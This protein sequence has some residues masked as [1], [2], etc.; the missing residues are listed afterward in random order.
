MKIK[1][2]FTALLVL[3]FSFQ[4]LGQIKLSLEECRVMALENN[5]QVQIADEHVGAAEALRKSAKTNFLPNI[6]ANGS[7]T[8]TNKKFSLLEEDLFIPVV[9]YS[10]LDASGS[11]LN[12]SL[13]SPTLAD[14]TTANPQFDASVFSQTFAVDPSTGT[15]YVDADN[16]PVFGNYA[17]IPQE[18]GELGHKNIYV[19]ALTLTQP[20]YLGGK[21]R[22]AYKITKY[23][24][25][26]AAASKEADVA[27]VLYKT[28]EAYWRVLS[29]GEK[30][31]LVNAYIDLLQRLNLDL[32]NLFAE[33]I[34]IQNDLLKAGVKLN[35]ARL[36]LIKAENGLALSKMALCQILGLPL[37][38][39][40]SLTDDLSSELPGMESLS[41]RD[42]AVANR[43]ELHALEQTANIARSGVKLMQSRY[44]PNVGFTAN[45]LVANPNP[46]AGLT[47]DFGSDWTV[48]VAVNIPIFH[49]GDKNHTLRAAKYEQR[50]AE[51]KLEETRDLITLEVQQALFKVKESAR[52]VEVARQNL[53]KADENLKVATD[54][55]AE[56]ILK[57]TD[58]LEAQALWKESRS[59]YIDAKMERNLDRVNLEKVAGDLK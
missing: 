31:S 54:G 13:L 40:L 3:A 23:G 22:E 12:S 24:E 27:D 51:L 17:W 42:S 21:V 58:V 15:P 41:Y 29:L 44:L 50:V 55:F 34:I 59:S 37:E 57:T 48:G 46:Y 2:T 14:G 4:G 9:P 6:S 20:V 19:G 10:A 45:Y 52:K 26:L 32:E 28:E 16:N 38:T 8:R 53:E 5:H 33:G 7:Y 36:N 11:G 1:A 43:P 25:Q 35:E 49:W 39:D 30:V 47:E 18:E 56:G